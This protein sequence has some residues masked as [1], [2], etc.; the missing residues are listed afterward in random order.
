MTTSAHDITPTFPSSI[1]STMLASFTECPQ[2]FFVE[3]ILR[4]SPQGFSPDLHA[5]GAFAAGIEAARKAVYFDKLPIDIAVGKG[6]REFAHYWGDYIP[7]DNHPKDFVNTGFALTEYFNEWNPYSDELQ[8]VYLPGGQPGIEYTFSIPMNINDP[9]TGTPILYSGRCDMVGERAGIPMIVDEKTAKSLGPKWVLK[10]NMRGQFLGYAYAV[11]ILD[12]NV[13]YALVRGVALQKTQT[14]FQ[15][16]TVP[17]PRFRQDQW[18]HSANQRV[19]L[20]RTIFENM[21][22]MWE[23]NKEMLANTEDRKLLLEHCHSYWIK[24]FGESCEMYGGCWLKDTCIRQHVAN[25]YGNFE[26]N[27][28]DPLAKNPT[29]LNEQPFLG[30]ESIAVPDEFKKKMGIL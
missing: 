23:K 25:H 14:Q 24:A 6:L 5:G 28:W 19:Y 11:N 30:M 16:A 27:T 9:I 1:D 7:P 17:L 4:L 15:E 20:I 21:M 13:E 18:W 12:I 2:K 22:D 8:P 10:W 29:H 3:Y 26:R